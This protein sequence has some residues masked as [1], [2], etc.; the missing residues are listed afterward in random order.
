MLSSSRTKLP[1]KANFSPK[2]DR[3]ATLMEPNT[4]LSDE[5]SQIMMDLKSIPV[6]L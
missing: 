6:K 1:E 4:P 5:N 3:G 2:I